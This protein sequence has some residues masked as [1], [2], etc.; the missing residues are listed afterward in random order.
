MPHS[1]GGGSSHG[2][3]HSSSRSSKSANQRYGNRYYRGANR[4]VYYR[5]GAPQYYYSEEPYTLETARSEK[6]RTIFSNIISIFFGVIFALF[7]LSSLPQKVKIDYNT[8]IVIND[9]ARLLNSAEEGEMR[10]AFTAFQNRTG[11]TPA[12]YSLSNKDLQRQYGGDLQDF[13]YRL[14]TDTFEDEKH[15]LVVYC[16][17][18]VDKSWAWEG[19]IGNDCGNIITTDLENEFTDL[20][21]KNLKS[22]PEMV[23]ASVINAFNTIGSKASKLPVKEIPFLAFA[24]LGGGFFAFS[25]VDK[26]IKT[27]KKKVEED[28]RI[29]SV[30]CP[31]AE[32]EPVTVKCEHCGGE[33]VAGLH[34]TCPHC[35]AP[36]E[37]WE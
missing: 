2:G 29:N 7:G 28:P 3:S 19:M 16:I 21:H 9:T 27:S 26:I 23:S 13:A 22:N 11:V 6:I 32:T 4:Y 24:I 20:L 17:N 10:D 12:F 30:L 37:N 15:W 25:A 36:V 33:Y 5:N 34:M 8:E 14:Y 31:T 1:S 35:G 18:N